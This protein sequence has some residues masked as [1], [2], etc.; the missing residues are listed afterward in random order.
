M[1]GP[2]SENCFLE[3][4]EESVKVSRDYSKDPRLLYSEQI[5]LFFD[6]IHIKMCTGQL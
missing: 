3:I 4:L 6:K 5:L 2:K 1:E